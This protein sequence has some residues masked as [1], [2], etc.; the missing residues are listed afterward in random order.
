M[1]ARR[2]L[3]DGGRLRK[4]GDRALLEREPVFWLGRTARGTSVYAES[5]PLACPCCGAP[6][7]TLRTER[8]VAVVLERAAP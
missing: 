2:I 4:N 5:V 1:T 7:G 6:V 3:V 8:G